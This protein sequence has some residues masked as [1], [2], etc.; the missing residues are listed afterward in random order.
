[1]LGNRLMVGWDKSVSKPGMNISNQFRCHCIVNY[2]TM[3]PLSFYGG[4]TQAMLNKRE[5]EMFQFA[6]NEW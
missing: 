5:P 6:K 4:L 2:R 1:M 3:N